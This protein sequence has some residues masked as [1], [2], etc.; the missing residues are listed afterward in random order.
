MDFNV[1]TL[2]ERYGFPVFAVVAMM[3]F[4][5]YTWKWATEEIRPTLSAANTDLINLVDRIRL[6]DNDLIRLDQRVRVVLQ[7]RAEKIDREARKS[8]E[9]INA[10]GHKSGS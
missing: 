4:I 10:N 2:I 8:K 1:A 5:W 6:M 3:Y 7:L 9:I